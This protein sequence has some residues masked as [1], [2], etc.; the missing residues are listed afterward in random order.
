M[1]QDRPI[2]FRFAIGFVLSF[3]YLAAPA[4]ADFQAGT[5]AYQRRDYPTALKEWRPLAEQGNAVAQS[6]LGLLYQN[7]RG[8]PQDY[9][10]AR[11]WY[12]KAA[13]QGDAVAQHNLGL[14][15]ANGWGVPQDYVQARQWFEKAAVQ[16]DAKAQHSLGLLYAKGQGVSQDFVQ[17]YMWY[18][19]A[20]ANG[21]KEGA[22]IRD[23]LVKR[24]TPAQIAEAQKR[25]R[26]WKPKTNAQRPT[27]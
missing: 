21:E 17:A 12:E 2:S 13:A 8:V 18:S 16:R 20:I 10:Q 7:G 11:Q 22:I 27:P 19:L 5:D 24:M 1:I 15:Y 3:I 4:W 23:A 6:N 14:L 25:A 9:V 26:E